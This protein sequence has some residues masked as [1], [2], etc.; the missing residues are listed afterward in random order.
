VAQIEEVATLEEHR[1]RGY[2]RAVV[3]TAIE[4]AQQ[5]GHRVLIINATADDWP[6]EMYRRLGFEA[7][8]S[9]HE[10]TRLPGD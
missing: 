10:L 5:S 1:G 6:K 9:L 7:I 3:R 8:S 4:A 2:A